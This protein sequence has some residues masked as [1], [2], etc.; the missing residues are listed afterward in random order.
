[1]AT[2][3]FTSLTKEKLQHIFKAENEL[4]KAGV[5]FDTGSDI[6]DG[7][8]IS[9]EWELDWSLSGAELVIRE[10]DGVAKPVKVD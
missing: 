5:T 9:R 1:M 10:D 7:R 8:K 3:R 6:E 2:L 4:S